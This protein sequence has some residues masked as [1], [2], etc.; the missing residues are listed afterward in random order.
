MISVRLPVAVYVCV[1][2]R[3]RERADW[4]YI[5]VDGWVFIDKGI[6]ISQVYT[7]RLGVNYQVAPTQGGVGVDAN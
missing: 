3:E 2:E 7:R 5:P 1:C 4:I 6:I